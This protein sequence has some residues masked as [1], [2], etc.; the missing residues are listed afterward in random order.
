MPGYKRLPLYTE[1]PLKML[2][3]S[4]NLRSND[5]R[6]SNLPILAIMGHC[7]GVTLLVIGCFT[8]KCGQGSF[9][10]NYLFIRTPIDLFDVI[11]YAG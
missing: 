11:F 5:C 9:L 1:T 2:N 4:Q 3:F 7:F 8:R 10:F 6:P